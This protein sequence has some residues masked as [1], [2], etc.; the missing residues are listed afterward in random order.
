[1]ATWSRSNDHSWPVFL[2]HLLLIFAKQ[3]EAELRYSVPEEV[4]EGTVVGNI[5]K[6]LGLEKAHL[7]DRRLRIVSGSENTFFSHVMYYSIEQ[8]CKYTGTT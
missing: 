3:T 7:T 5:A 8:S 1:M 6:D 4:K 2:L